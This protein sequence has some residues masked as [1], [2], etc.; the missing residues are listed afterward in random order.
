MGNIIGRASFP[1]DDLEDFT[2]SCLFFLNSFISTGD[3]PYCSAL[4]LFVICPSPCSSYTSSLPETFVQRI[5]PRYL[6]LRGC[7]KSFSLVHGYRLDLWELQSW[8]P[9]TALFIP[10]HVEWSKSLSQPALTHSL[11]RRGPKA[12]WSA[13]F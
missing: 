1:L 5:E 3:G 4:G 10:S 7:C 8:H 11:S 13:R 2:G 9:L 12:L 6:R